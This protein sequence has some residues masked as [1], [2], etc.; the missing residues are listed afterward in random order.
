[1]N[2][3]CSKN[4]QDKER[5]REARA[6]RNVETKRRERNRKIVDYQE[7]LRNGICL[8]KGASEGGQ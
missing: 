2:V 4:V 3:Y 7:L 5:E 1:M 6:R 8:M